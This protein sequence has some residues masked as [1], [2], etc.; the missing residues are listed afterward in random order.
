[1]E[2]N[3]AAIR[4]RLAYAIR[5]AVAAGL[6]L[7]VARLIGFPEA[8]W[9]PITTLIVMQPGLEAAISIAI[10]RFAGTALGAAAGAM[11]A[12]WFGPSA[13]MFAVGIFVLGPVCF[14][15]Q[16]GPVGYRFASITLAIVML[17]SHTE[18]G[19]VA[20]HRFVEVSVGIAVGL[21]MTAVW[22][23]RVREAAPEQSSE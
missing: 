8:Y 12:A 19:V 22:P 21:F 6:S 5:T 4:Q 15:L 10:Y 23:E 20:V 11:L 13:M 9:A 18:A 2:V 3:G 17:A 1:M 16:M 14:L 7:V